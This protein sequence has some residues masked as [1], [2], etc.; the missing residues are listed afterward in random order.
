MK[1]ITILLLVAFLCSV[2]FAQETEGN[3]QEY[4]YKTFTGGFWSCTTHTGG[5]YGEFGFRLIPEDKGFVLRNSILI[6]GEGGYI[7]NSTDSSFGGLFLGDKISIG[8]CL[9]TGNSVIRSYGF[10]TCKA[11]MFG[12]K[13]HS[14]FNPNL[15][16]GINAGGGFEFQFTRRSAFAV[17]FGGTVS[18]VA[19]PDYKQYSQ[20]TKGTPTLT[21]GYRSLY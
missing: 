19:G 21:I 10:L 8:S 13:N 2:G 9:K 20:F 6:G 11:E 18:F 7:S 16:Y 12:A 1:R 15:M 5:G 4:S 14:F 3:N 17:E